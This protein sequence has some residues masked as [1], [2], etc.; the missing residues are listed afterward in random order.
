MPH[1]QPEMRGTLEIREPLRLLPRPKQ[2]K[3]MPKRTVKPRAPVAI[4]FLLF[5]NV[6]LGVAACTYT[7]VAPPAP[8]T[9]A[10]DTTPPAAE[11]AAPGLVG[12]DEA[13]TLLDAGIKTGGFGGPLVK[14][15]EMNDELSVIVGGRGGAIYNESFVVGGCL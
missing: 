7:G 6:V 11:E 14:F 2:G 9:P 8:T 3:E 15:T 13:E 10:A 1:S 4:L 12:A 5:A